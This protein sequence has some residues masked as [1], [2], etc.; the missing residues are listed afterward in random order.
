AALERVYGPCGLDVG[1][2]TPAETAMSILAEIMAVRAGREGSHLREA[3]TR[4]HAEV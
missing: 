4:I 2:Q 3:T 1:A